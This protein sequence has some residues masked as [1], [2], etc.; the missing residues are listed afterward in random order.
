MFKVTLI[1]ILFLLSGCL[2]DEST[3]LEKFEQQLNKDAETRIDAAYIAIQR[4][5]DS[6]VTYEI[7]RIADSIS[8]IKRKK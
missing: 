3:N 7:P 4:H 2:H 1:F 8:S 5:C 6:V